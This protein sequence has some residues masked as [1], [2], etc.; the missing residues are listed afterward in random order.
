MTLISGSSFSCSSS[1]LHCKLIVDVLHSRRCDN[2]LAPIPCLRCCGFLLIPSQARD[3]RVAFPSDPRQDLFESLIIGQK[4]E[5]SAEVD[6]SGMRTRAE[7]PNYVTDVDGEKT[8]DIRYAPEIPSYFIHRTIR[9]QKLLWTLFRV[10]PAD[11]TDGHEKILAWVS[12]GM[13]DRACPLM[14]EAS[15][16]RGRT[17]ATER[18]REPEVYRHRYEIQIEIPSR[19]CWH[20]RPERKSDVPVVLQLVE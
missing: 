3:S 10:I 16:N 1:V 11:F 13:A 6:A 19:R 18:R 4:K 2:I 5:G 8:N 9:N 15:D 12:F 17:F 14:E 20:R 7:T